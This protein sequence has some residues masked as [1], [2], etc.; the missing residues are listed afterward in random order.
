MGWVKIN[1]VNDLPEYPGEYL[2]YVK[3]MFNSGELFEEL[4]Y[5]FY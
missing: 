2:V 4:S 3:D 5:V 1:S